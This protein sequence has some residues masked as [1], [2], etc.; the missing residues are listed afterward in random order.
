MNLFELSQYAFMQHAFIAGTVIG[1]VSGI[2]GYFV[3]LKQLSFTCHALS[4]IGFAGACGAAFL[5]FSLLNG[6]LLLTFIAAMLM[7]LFGD[8]I[9]KND[10]V[11]AVIL[12]FS[13]GLGSLFL[14]LNNHYAGG[15][16]RILFG[17]L[18]IISMDDLS[19]IVWLSIACV[20]A[21]AIV[22]RPLWFVSLLPELAVA[23]G[24]RVNLVN[25]VFFGILAFVVTLVSKAVGIL[26]IFTLLTGPAS[27]ALK[28]KQEF[29]SGIGLSILF[30]LIVIYTGLILASITNWPLSFWISAIVLFAFTLTFKNLILRDL[31]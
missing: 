1:I 27:I 15:A 4:H 12:A 22:A 20:V 8:R 16:T 5:G 2:V 3:V 25:Y 28:F 7:V 11:I 6:Q 9:R 13:L 18:F 23:K 14:Y 24:I 17:D 31:C 21:I 10:T 19:Q 29:W 30:N 26:L